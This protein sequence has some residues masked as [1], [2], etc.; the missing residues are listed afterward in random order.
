M[1]NNEL[2]QNEEQVQEPIIIE[3]PVEETSVEEPVTEEVVEE[4]AVVSEPVQTVETVET[5]QPSVTIET[6]KKKSA[7]PVILFLLVLVGLGV[8]GYF[9]AQKF[10]GKKTPKEMFMSSI[11]KAVKKNSNIKEKTF[12]TLSDKFNIKVKVS[13]VMLDK[14]LLDIINKFNISGKVEVDQK[15]NKFYANIDTTYDKESLIKLSTYLEDNTMYMMF[16][17]LLNKWIKMDVSDSSFDSLTQMTTINSVEMGKYGEL[18]EEVL[19]VFKNSL[20]EKYFVSEKVDGGNKISIT[21]D[22]TNIKD[23]L[24]DFAKELKKSK[25][26]KKLYKEVTGQ[27]MTDSQIDEFVSQINMMDTSSSS[28]GKIIISVTT[29]SKNELT[30]LDITLKSASE[31]YSFIIEQTSDDT[32]EFAVKTQGIKMF[33]GSYTAKEENGKSNVVFKVSM[34]EMIN[35]ELDIDEEIKYDVDLTK[36]DVS[37]AVVS[38]KLTD[39]DIAKLDKISDTKGMKKLIEDLNKVDLSSLMESFGGSSSFSF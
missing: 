37:N 39:A 16:D 13:S 11:E 4:P 25:D 7:L 12:N 24:S 15:N 8:G 3:E 17:D 19:K 23:I 30:K 35:I 27:E 9:L 38:D 29:N 22:S 1:E 2:N 26:Y 32:V 18:F 20:N 28:D 21:I 34:M 6:P 36:V 5:V 33:S 31:E 14:E 10:I